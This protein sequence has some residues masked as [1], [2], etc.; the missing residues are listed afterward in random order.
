M[1]PRL[2]VLAPARRDGVTV[3]DDLPYP[4]EGGPGSMLVPGR[5]VTRAIVAAAARHGTDRI[6]FG[7]PWPLVLTGPRLARAGLRYASIV[8][9]AEL[10]VP[11][12]VPGLKRWLVHALRGA[13]LLYAVS[14]YTA[15]Q[16]RDLIG[17]SGRPEVEILR[18]R[19][20]VARFRPE[21]GTVDVRARMGI[22]EGA[23]VVLCFGRVVAR[24]GV[25]R[26]IE[27]LPAVRERVPGAIVVVAGTGPRLKAARRLA[28]RT[29]APVV[30][31]GR[32]PDEDAPSL[33]ATAA[34][35]ALP[36]ADRWGGLEVE[37]LG[38][39]L[40]EAAASGVPCV[41]GRSGGT[42]EAVIDGET[43]FVVNGRDVAALADRIA[44]LL[45]HPADARSMGAAG[46]EY[47]TR[48]FAD[49]PLPASLLEWLG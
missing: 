45:E 24:K 8:H 36:V 23:E 15:E 17:P 20:D 1:S 49:R 32:V 4:V 40:L 10:T 9:G 27:A 42:P 13:D 37:G 41:T 33:Y 21:A 22:P 14:E 44:W 25:D 34:V 3:P 18:A 2:A 5:S 12:A 28:A 16:I 35:F 19:V 46:R 31:A 30:F 29:G 7:T 6:L 48:V 26:L 11:A 38:V 47:V 39:V 43:G